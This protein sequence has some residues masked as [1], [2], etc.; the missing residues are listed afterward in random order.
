MGTLEIIA[1]FLTIS[2]SSVSKSTLK[3][4]ALPKVR[5]SSSKPSIKIPSAV[6][7]QF[8]GLRHHLALD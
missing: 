2:P 6:S 8:L 5:P 3:D 7:Y 4:Q 1:Q